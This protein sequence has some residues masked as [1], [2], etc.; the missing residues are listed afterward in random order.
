M[1]VIKNRF[2][3]LA[4]VLLGIENKRS[5]LDLDTIIVRDHGQ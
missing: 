3:F 1:I 5:I 2:D 4:L